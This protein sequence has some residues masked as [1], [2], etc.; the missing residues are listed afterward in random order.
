MV[1]T[2]DGGVHSFHAKD[3]L[4]LIKAIGS[5]TYHYVPKKLVEVGK[6][7]HIKKHN[8]VVVMEKWQ[9]GR[10]GSSGDCGKS[11]ICFCR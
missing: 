2:H 6:K 11:L 9:R 1:Y 10:E 8:T 4:G 3:D 5:K 7:T